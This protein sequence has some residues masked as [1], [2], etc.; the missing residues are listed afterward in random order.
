MNLRGFDPSGTPVAAGGRR[1]AGSSTRFGVTAEQIPDSLDAQ[2]ALYRSVLA[3]KRVLVMLD[4]ARDAA[5]V[6]PLLPG[7]PACLVLVTS[8]ARLHR[9]GRD[10]GRAACCRWTC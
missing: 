4:N 10:R 7:S 2:A 1:C 5:Q 6:R 3:G 8:R 9:A